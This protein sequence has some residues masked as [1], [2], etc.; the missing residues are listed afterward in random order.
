MY[1]VEY[2][3]VSIMSDGTLGNICQGNNVAYMDCDLSEIEDNL[4]GYLR[5]KE[6]PISPIISSVKKIPGHIVRFPEELMKN[7]N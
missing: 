7:N 5:N 4:E 3:Y 2:E 1:K 6:K